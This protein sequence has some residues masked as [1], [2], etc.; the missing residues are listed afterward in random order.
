MDTRGGP[1]PTMGRA[2][3][4]GDDEQLRAP[5]L[6]LELVSWDLRRG[7]TVRPA[8]TLLFG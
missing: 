1:K 2:A 5:Y 6:L 4:R 7:N 3:K 8:I